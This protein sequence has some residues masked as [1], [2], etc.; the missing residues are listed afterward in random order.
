MDILKYLKRLN[1]ELEIKDNVFIFTLQDKSIREIPQKELEQYLF[2]QLAEYIQP[3]IF[4]H[5][6]NI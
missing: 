5:I 4:K 3:G 2:M 6:V 1:I